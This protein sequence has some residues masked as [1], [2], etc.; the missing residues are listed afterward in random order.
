MSLQRTASAVH[1]PS[2]FEHPA[3]CYAQLCTVR[4]CTEYLRGLIRHGP[5]QMVDSAGALGAIFYY[6]V[7][8]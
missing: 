7:M 1:D 3:A 5:Y 8:K 2:S 6:V 4:T